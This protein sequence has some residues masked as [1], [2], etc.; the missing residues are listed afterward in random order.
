MVPTMSFFL[1]LFKDCK[2]YLV[3]S[4]CWDSCISGFNKMWNE[5]QKLFLEECRVFD[6]IHNIIQVVSFQSV[7][8]FFIANLALADVIIGLFAI[9]FQF[10]AALLQRWNL[11]EFLCPFCPFF[12]VNNNK[13]I[14]ILKHCIAEFE[15]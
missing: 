8:N 12:Q 10:Q 14:F 11:P 1:L 7:T 3:F 2:E 15:C 4:G 5:K 13:K 9:P 6:I